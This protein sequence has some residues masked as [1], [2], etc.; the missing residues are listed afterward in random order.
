MN[1]CKIVKKSKEQARR[2]FTQKQN[3]TFL[4]KFSKTPFNERIIFVP[5]CMR[6]TSLCKA[7]ERDSYYICAN[8]GQ[9][10]IGA[11]NELAKDFGYKSVYI[12][13]GGRAITKIIET[14]HPK[15]VLG[16]ACFYE[17]DL[18][19]KLLKDYDLAVQFVGLTKDGCADT[20]ADLSAVSA[21]LQLE[22]K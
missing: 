8:C 2:V 19:F 9:C 3:K 5:H 6:K 12:L 22:E 11:I 21:I 4:K 1:L 14:V 17:G 15:A 13:K 18:A 20:D 10:K 16:I 7:E